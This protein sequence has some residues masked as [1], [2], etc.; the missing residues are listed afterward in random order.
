MASLFSKASL[1]ALSGIGGLILLL[2]ALLFQQH[3]FAALALAADGEQCREDSI[4]DR[5]EESPYKAQ[6]VSCAGFL[7]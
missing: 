7:E 3:G 5:P 2:A 4:S 6:F 1:G